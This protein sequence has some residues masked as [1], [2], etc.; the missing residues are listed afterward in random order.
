MTFHFGFKDDTFFWAHVYICNRSKA[1]CGG[2]RQ[3]GGK[4]ENNILRVA[5]INTTQQ[6]KEPFNK[7]QPYL[8]AF[9]KYFF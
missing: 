2:D 3:T 9:F 5:H 6:I 4:C 7:T 1:V 8:F